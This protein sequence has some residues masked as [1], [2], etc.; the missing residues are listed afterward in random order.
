MDVEGSRYDHML[1]TS[2]NRVN[3]IPRVMFVAVDLNDKIMQ[4]W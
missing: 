2:Q 3:V 4:K 1:V